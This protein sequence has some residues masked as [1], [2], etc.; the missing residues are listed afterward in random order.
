[1]KR[2]QLFTV[3][4]AT[5]MLLSTVTKINSSARETTAEGSGTPP[6]IQQTEIPE[7]TETPSPSETSE[8]PQATENPEESPSAET[9]AVPSSTV[10]PAP[11]Q[12]T[13]TPKTTRKPATTG[14]IAK[15]WWER[16]NGKRYYRL[17]D[18]TYLKGVVKIKKRIFA[19]SS[20][21]SDTTPSRLLTGK[22]DRVLKIKGKKYHVD[23]KGLALKGWYLKGKHLYYFNGKLHCAITNRTVQK[24]RLNK[25]GYAIQDANSDAKI[26]AMKVIQEITDPWDSKSRKLSKAFSYITH[27]R[28][29]RYLPKYP[30]M[31]EASW[32]RKLGADMLHTHSGNC[33]GFACGFAAL[34][35][36]IGYQPQIICGRVR[37]SRDRAADGFTRHAVVRINGRYYDPEGW[38]KG[39]VHARGSAH[40]PI[41]IKIIKA[42]PF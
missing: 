38:W 28:K 40:Y 42:V 11:P 39:F 21:G 24:I 23:K 9:P 5:I 10:T 41:A 16:K 26:E 33:Y 13:G 22:K 35:K 37:G 31:H 1:M 36:E 25:S 8:A 27:P 18:G 29:W 17:E 6:A 15:G 19:F 32:P 14:E 7:A 2:K 30:N 12:P 20:K 4:L 3:I 34:A